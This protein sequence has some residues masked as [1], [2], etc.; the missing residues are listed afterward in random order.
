MDNH[1]FCRDPIQIFITGGTFHKVYDVISQKL[2]FISTYV[3]EILNDGRSTLNIRTEELML[4]DSLE[5]TKED[6]DLI[7]EK[8]NQCDANRIIIIHGT[9]TVCKN[10]KS[11]AK[12]IA[13]DKIIIMTGSI[14][15]YKCMNSDAPFNLSCAL[16]FIQLLEPGVH[17][18]MNGK[19]HPFYKVIKNYETGYF[20]C[21]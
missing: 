13:K 19:C 9:D 15:P 4:K 14:V 5:I 12:A 18:V 1:L 17:I 6:I 2:T 7:I 11:I 3:H 21:I 8:C 10:A 16:A 20:D